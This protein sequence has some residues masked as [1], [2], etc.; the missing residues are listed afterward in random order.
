M[1]Q[2]AWRRLLLL[3][4][5]ALLGVVI[6]LLLRMWS[7]LLATVS[8]MGMVS[9]LVRPLL[10]LSVKL[11]CACI[12]CFGEPEGCGRAIHHRIQRMAVGLEE[13]KCVR[14]KV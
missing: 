1:M 11:S 3:Q 12:S 10:Q 8:Q 6:Q 2:Q 7:L 4:L 14:R 13:I 5:I 9:V